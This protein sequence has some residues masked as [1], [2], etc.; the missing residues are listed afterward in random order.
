MKDKTITRV[1]PIPRITT[2]ANKT[3]RKKQVTVYC[4]AKSSCTG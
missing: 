2:I 1:V 4:D 3:K